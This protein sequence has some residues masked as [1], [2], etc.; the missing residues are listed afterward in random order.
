MERTGNGSTPSRNFID[1]ATRPTTVDV[2]KSIELA[3]ILLELFRRGQPLPI[4][5]ERLLLLIAK[6]D[7]AAAVL[8]G[9]RE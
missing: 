5:D 7:Q 1:P 4:D 6:L 8:A 2:A 3:A 9:V